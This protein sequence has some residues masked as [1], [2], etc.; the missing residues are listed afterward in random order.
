M[1]RILNRRLRRLEEAA[2]RRR[3]AVTRPTS[4]APLKSELLDRAGAVRGPNESAAE[5]RERALGLTAWQL[6]AELQQQ[7]ARGKASGR[8]L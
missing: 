4:S 5:A 2:T 3:I 6:R 7:A 8:G 1:N